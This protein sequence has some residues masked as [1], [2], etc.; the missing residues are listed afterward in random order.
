MESS[1]WYG[2][3]FPRAFGTYS[4]DLWKKARRAS[5]AQAAADWL[6]RLPWW[7]MSVERPYAFA[8]KSDS[9]YM[10][11]KTLNFGTFRTLES[12]QRKGK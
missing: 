5:N 9:R 6:N 12:F 3:R 4:K 8:S 2:L 1:R 10:S 7:A 11:L